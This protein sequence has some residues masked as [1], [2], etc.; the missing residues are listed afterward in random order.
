MP[1]PIPS[2]MGRAIC[3]YLAH[4]DQ[5]RLGYLRRDLLPEDII[6]VDVRWDNGA[7]SDP[8]YE[9]DNESPV[10]EVS[11]TF[12]SRPELD[13]LGLNRTGTLTK[14]LD[15]AWVVEE[16]LRAALGLRRSRG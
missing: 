5:Y 9:R 4:R 11:V 2:R 15:P 10:F 7:S 8:T 6:D 16:L 1:S 13:D 12:R 3:S 14:Q